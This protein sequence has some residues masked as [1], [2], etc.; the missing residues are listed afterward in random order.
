MNQINV[1]KHNDYWH[2]F[3]YDNK[4]SKPLHTA[5]YFFILRHANKLGWKTEFGLPT[6]Y[7]MEAIGVKSHK[8]YVNALED[9]ESFG[10]IKII[11]RSKNQF[12]SNV[13][14][15]INHEN[16]KENESTK[17]VIS[18]FSKTQ[19]PVK[20]KEVPVKKSPTEKEPQPEKDPLQ[21]D[22]LESTEEVTTSVSIPKKE[23]IDFNSLRDF[24]NEKTGRQ[25]KVVNDSVKAKYRKLLKQGYT[26]E[27]VFLAIEVA[28]DSKYHLETNR[29]YL[30]LEFFS[31]PEK[32]DTYG[33]KTTDTTK[34]LNDYATSNDQY[35]DPNRIVAG[36]STQKDIEN[37]A[38]TLGI[39]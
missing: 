16:F 4:K 18:Q 36:R 28:S 27:D 37:L 15:I 34:T 14:S 22:L 33:V 8:T 39:L 24:L 11:E 9:L 5:V 25:F 12:T 3:I 6:E 7:S 10:F 32:I 35:N 13:V 2:D 31:R 20:P 19:D 17:Q 38:K 29:K 30:T 1:F 26:M 23:T 21:I